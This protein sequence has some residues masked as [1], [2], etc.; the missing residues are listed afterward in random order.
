V[1]LTTLAAVVTGCAFE[2]LILHL[3]AWLPPRP[4]NA[5]LTT[6]ALFAVFASV[7]GFLAWRASVA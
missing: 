5:L 7:A 2:L 4:R 6:G 3:L 1:T